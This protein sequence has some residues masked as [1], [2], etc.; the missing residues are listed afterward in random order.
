MP[1]TRQEYAELYIE[2]LGF[3][4]CMFESGTKGPNTHGWNTPSLYIDAAEKA[5]RELSR[6]PNSN[7]GVIHEASNTVCIDVDHFEYLVIALSIF[8][9]DLTETLKSGVQLTSGR[10]NRAKAIFRQPLALTGCKTKKLNWPDPK[11]GAAIGILELRGGNVQDV[12][13]PSIHPDTQKPY[14]WVD[15]PFE[16]DEIPELPEI[17]TQIWLNWDKIKPQLEDACP[18]KKTKNSPPPP[19]AQ[20]NTD[21][22]GLKII[23]AFNDAH[24][25][26]I[27]LQAHGYLPRGKRLLAPSSS[28]KLAGVIFFE[29]DR[30][31]YSHHGSCIFG[32]GKRHDSFDI[33]MQFECE[34]SMTLAIQKAKTLL[35]L[36]EPQIIVDFSQIKSQTKKTPKPKATPKTIPKHLLTPPGILGDITRQILDSARLPQP[37][38]AV[39]AALMLVSTLLARRVQTPTGLRTN[40]YIISLGPTGCGKEHARNYIKNM[41]NELGRAEQLGGEDI[42]SGQGLMARAAATPDALFQ[43]D[44]FGDFLASAADKN[45]AS[46]KVGILTNFM[47]LFSSTSSVV[48]GTEYANQKMNER[49]LIEFPCVNLHATGTDGVF[50]DAL[51][52]RHIL[53]GYLNRIIVTQTDTARPEKQRTIP[54]L[55][56]AQPIIDWFEGIKTWLH[57]RGGMLAENNAQ[58]AIIVEFSKKA[59]QLFDA[60]DDRINKALEEHRGTGLDSLYVRVWE[61]AAKIAL[62]CG[63]AKPIPFVDEIEAAY[64]IDYVEHWTDGLVEAA[65]LRIADTDF[66][67]M[68]NAILMRLKQAGE[69]GM[70]KG[71]L[72][73]HKKLREI[74]PSL[75]EQL[76]TA[77]IENGEIQV[78]QKPTTQKGGRATLLYRVIENG[79]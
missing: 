43:I 8:G 59:W 2:K 53:D 70:T 11:T 9:I 71:R 45:A 69:D 52:G 77:L 28:T 41:L 5:E 54:Q 30:H 66:G 23:N 74:Q 33:F 18:W 13:P 26:K 4:L 10:S 7:M 21:G 63:C 15:N 42:A 55:K 37:V 57:K 73:N 44:E 79:C 68:M 36:D 48:T 75:R 40:L 3:G 31:F 35:G 47:K 51:S 78:G 76:M 60:L 12:L 6:K 32:D 20:R 67:A 38:F 19:P 64:A 61:H 29:E 46:Y 72:F 14:E 50:Y 16:L 34:G 25:P 62:V 27:M 49:Q 56:P 1:N 58:N 22:S 24:N 65:K 17:I 39:N